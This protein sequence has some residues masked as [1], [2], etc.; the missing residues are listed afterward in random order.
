MECTGE[1]NLQTPSKHDSPHPRSLS[2]TSWGMSW[3]S[4]ATLIFKLQLTPTPLHFWGR[5]WVPQATL[6]G[7]LQR[8]KE[9]KKGRKEERKEERKKE[10]TKRK[11]NIKEKRTNERRKERQ[12]ASWMP[13]DMVT[14]GKKAPQVEFLSSVLPILWTCRTQFAWLTPGLLNIHGWSKVVYRFSKGRPIAFQRF[15]HISDKKSYKIL[16]D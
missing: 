16:Q 7:G 12:R 5:Y 10:R 13:H 11:K 8:K 4:Q 1:T 2:G 15:V 6:K 3:M 14:A 9:R